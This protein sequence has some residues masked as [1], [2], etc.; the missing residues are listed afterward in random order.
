MSLD[1]F[2][3]FTAEETVRNN[4]KNLFHDISELE[5]STNKGQNDES[6][7]KV[8]HYSLNLDWVIPFGIIVVCL[9]MCYCYAVCIFWTDPN[10]TQ[11]FL[12]SKITDATELEDQ[13]EDI[14]LA[15]KTSVVK[16]DTSL[17]ES[18]SKIDLCQ[19]SIETEDTFV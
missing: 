19:F 6:G 1:F 5:A 3:N 7:S 18:I 8:Y 13:N 2:S 11:T 12:T 16:R 9:S 14:S 4:L 15:N 17:A 10:Q